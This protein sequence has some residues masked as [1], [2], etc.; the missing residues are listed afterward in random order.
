VE[1]VVTAASRASASKHDVRVAPFALV[2]VAAVA[3]GQLAATT[4]PTLAALVANGEAAA[5]ELERLRST[6]EAALFAAVPRSEPRARRPLLAVLRDVHNR[7]IPHPA[8]V[9]EVAKLSV[10]HQAEVS[11]WLTSTATLRGARAQAAALWAK[12]IDGELRGALEHLL[13]E[14]AL[15]RP[16]AVSSPELSRRL[17]E[18][19]TLARGR[20]CSNKLERSLFNFAARAAAKTS[21]FSTFL[22][23]G[24]VRFDDTA[25]APTLAL[26][27]SARESRA[28]VNPGIAVALA[29]ALSAEPGFAG[30]VPLRLHPLLRWIDDSTVEF[31]RSVGVALGGRLWRTS[32]PTR[33][34]LNSRVAAVLRGLDAVFSHDHLL[35]RLASCTP[36]AR[37][38]AA[39][40]LAAQLV[41]P[42]G[43]VAQRGLAASEAF[44]DA[45]SRAGC[46]AAHAHAERLRQLD[47]LAAALPSAGPGERL[48]LTEE[49]RRVHAGLRGA[50]QAVPDGLAPVFEDGVWRRNGA[51]RLGGVPRDLVAE[52]GRVLQP[53]VVERADYRRLLDGFLA[54]FGA[55]GRCNDIAD[56][57][58]DVART[59]GDVAPALRPRPITAGPLPS[60]AL[61]QLAGASADPLLVV[62]QLYV[63]CGML[64][65]RYA[66]DDPELRAALVAWLRTLA[67]DSRLLDVTLSS[68]CNPLQRHPTLTEQRLA[69]PGEP[70]D[71]GNLAL[72]ELAI[73][74]DAF[75]DRLQLLH[76]D[77]TPLHPLWLGSIK[78]SPR[79]GMP[80]WLTLL[81]QP[82][83]VPPQ[84]EGVVRPPSG[85]GELV[86][87]PRLQRGRVV[88]QRARW[89]MSTER[90][91]RHW[92]QR[93]GAERLF[94]VAADACV[95]G[96]PRQLFV[97]AP[98]DERAPGDADSRKPLWIDRYNPFCLDLIE[99]LTA[100]QEW[101]CL[102]EALPLLGD[103]FVRV[104]GKPHTAELLVEFTL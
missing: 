11:H 98:L 83:E 45:C 1:V 63:G 61:V 58:A 3:A 18:R 30:A 60:T 7:R 84:S 14:D 22:H 9:A 95:L 79:A 78:L 37:A 46:G 59:T 97:R 47:A 85:A 57:L 103:S 65:A 77:G 38:A 54:R 4:P 50:T 32:L 33:L 75:C 21:P 66:Q 8:N 81:G 87:V 17:T 23:V 91:R 34:R 73:V 76:R 94:D 5:S 64:S 36:D 96:L 42:L 53:S 88:V 71:A 93:A 24:V 26:E 72:D 104:D 55:G 25:A 44:I 74:H 89:W 19:P 100:Q 20:P 41:R 92:F 2:R 82:Y 51:L 102:T 13:A 29:E 67:G 69:W 43:L 15:R 80:Y 40:L 39:R 6:V 35:A 31:P 12:S 99:A 48:A 16:L 70:C 27:G 62:N 101:L 56:F 10:A 49:A 28:Y 86:A 68:D 52:L 90:L